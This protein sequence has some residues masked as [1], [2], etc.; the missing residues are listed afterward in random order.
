MVTKGDGLCRLQVGEAGHDGI[1]F[2]AGQFDQALLQA[3][4]F[5]ADE[6]NF[7]AQVQADIGRDLIVTGAA[8]VQFFAGNTDFGSQRGF[9]VHMNVF[10][11]DRP[12]E[13][14][15]FNLDP[16]LFQAANNIVALGVGQ[17]ADMRQ[18]AG[19]GNRSLNVLT[20]HALVKVH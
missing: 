17:H 4:Q 8:G 20:V 2:P 7:V 3:G 13:I 18:H 19:M 14:A 11:R 15:A 9:D 10:Q 1:G 12:V 6:I 16:N 5:G